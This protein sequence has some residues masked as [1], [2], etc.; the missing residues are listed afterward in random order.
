ML[1]LD[2]EVE[3]FNEISKRPRH[4]IVRIAEGGTS[5]DAMLAW[6]VDL[7]QLVAAADDLRIY[8]SEAIAKYRAERR[9]SKEKDLQLTQAEH[10]VVSS[11]VVR[12]GVG[13]V[14]RVKAIQEPRDEVLEWCV[15]FCFR[16]RALS[17]RATDLALVVGHVVP[18]AI[19]DALGAED[20][21]TS[22]VD[23]KT[24]YQGKKK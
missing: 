7:V 19:T 10:H 14:V 21:S 15:T 5:C 20:L 9:E 22:K 6:H 8:P 4:E 13:M 11:T 3:D 17:D 1:F 2:V 12:E 24:S 23:L 16:P 18:S